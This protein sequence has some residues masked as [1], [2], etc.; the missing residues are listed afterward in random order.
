MIAN[1]PHAAPAFCAPFARPSR[2]DFRQSTTSNPGGQ[3]MLR[4]DAIADR[5]GS[6]INA[7]RGT[8]GRAWARVQPLLVVSAQDGIARRA[9][10]HLVEMPDYLLRDIGIARSD[11]GRAVRQGRT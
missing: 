5:S 6:G 11:I 1:F 4:S 9:E 7:L 8:L 10:R 3:S 2:H